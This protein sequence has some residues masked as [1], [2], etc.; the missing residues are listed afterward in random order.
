MGPNTDIPAIT[1]QIGALRHA[2]HIVYKLGF[3]YFPPGTADGDSPMEIWFP[4]R[5]RGEE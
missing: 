2:E 5:K 3:D 4:V 1:S